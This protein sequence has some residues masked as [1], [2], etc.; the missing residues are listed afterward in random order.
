MLNRALVKQLSPLFGAG[1][2]DAC[3]S[4]KDFGSM[5]SK[6]F[7]EK[8][9]T[10]AWSLG[11]VAMGCLPRRHALLLGHLILRKFPDGL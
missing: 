5:M 10:I 2:P 1:R 9:L 4:T 11:L 7:H 8:A 3:E 6:I